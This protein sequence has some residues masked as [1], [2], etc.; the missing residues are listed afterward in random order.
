LRAQPACSRPTPPPLA[1]AVLD[2]IRRQPFVY[3]LEPG[4]YRGDSVDEFWLD[5]RAGF[6]EHYAAAFVIVMRAM[7]VPARIVTGYQ[8]S[9]F[10]PDRRLPDRAPE[11]CPRLGRVLAGRPRLAARGSD[12]RRGAR[13]HPAQPGARAPPGSMGAAL[14]A[15]SP[16][17]RQNLRRFFEA[18]DNRWNQWILGYGKQQQFDLLGQLGVESPDLLS[19]AR[20]LV[21]LVVA[22]GAL[23]AVW[24]WVDARRQSPWQRLRQ[25]IARELGRLGIDVKPSDTLAALARRVRLAAGERAEAA[26]AALLALEQHRLRPPGP[27]RHAARLVAR[28]SRSRGSGPCSGLSGAPVDN[29][30]MSFRV[31][32][33]AALAAAIAL[34]AGAAA[35]KAPSNAPAVKSDSAPD[36]VVYGRRDDVVAFAREAAERQGFEADWAIEQ[37]AQARYQPTVARLVM[38]PPAG[39]AKNWAAYRSRFVEPQRIA[40]GLRWWQAQEAWLNQAEARWGVPPEMVVAIV[41]VE[42]F[43]G[44]ITGGFRVIDALATLSFDFPTGRSDRSGFY[45]GELE[46]FL[47]WCTAE[48]RDP[49]MVKGSFA[50]AM[51]WPQ[52][53]PSTAAALCPRFRRRRPDRPRRRRCRRRRQ[54]GALLRPVRLGKGHADPLRRHGAAE[55]RDRALMLVPTSCPASR[56]PVRRARR[57]ARRG[58][59]KHDGLLALVELQNGDDRAQLRGR[60]AQL[61]CRHALQLVELL[62]DGGDRAGAG[63][64]A[65]TA[66]SACTSC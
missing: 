15:V 4:S 56:R 26:A 39:T 42:T 20:V 33:A 36:V 66:G 25:G 47:A 41:G 10:L 60:H 2:H 58:R 30:R 64:A 22:V 49:L 54:R 16:D 37:L 53:M 31:V 61:L 50:G 59:P 29:P 62:R 27:R 1:R 38:P 51:G 7:G 17:L 19:L 57:P 40:A 48:G 44:R 46:A 65:G 12:R 24:A 55:I 8:G 6:C 9:D 21:G 23:G 35:R 28:L 45:Q 11:P 43:Y 18:L 32:C 34:P 52:F 5:R 14:G 63:A 13:A 3:T